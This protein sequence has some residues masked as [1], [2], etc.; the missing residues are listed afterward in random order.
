[1]ADGDGAITGVAIRNI[2]FDIGNVVVPWDPHGIARRALGEERVAQPGSK[3][4]FA[5]NPLWLAVN[6]GEHTLAE[7][8]DLYI[9]H[10]GLGGAEV[11]AL[12][13]ELMDSMVLIEATERLMRE[14][15]GAGHR[16][17]AITDN[18]REIVALL[19]QRHDFWPLFEHAAVSAELGV[20]KPDPRMYRH[21][22]DA[23][24]LKPEECLFFD[25]VQRNIEGAEAVGMNARLFTD[26]GQARRDLV[27]LGVEVAAA[28]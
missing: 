19:Q 28:A 27:D 8:K 5:G 24:S 26:A 15:A 17:F 23:G 18:V 7:A 20:L 16:L 9:A 21:I 22:L 13:D 2:V 3:H 4:P 12:F 14:L 25:D 11:D 6:R 10:H 1:M